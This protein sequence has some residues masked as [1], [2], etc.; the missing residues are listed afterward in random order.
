MAPR[1]P[2]TDT[3]IDRRVKFLIEEA[4]SP[5]GIRDQVVTIAFRVITNWIAVGDDVSS[6]NLKR[7]CL[8]RSRA[9]HELCLASD[10]KT[11]CANTIN[12]HQNPIKRS[13]AWM[14]EEGRTAA[15]VMAH[16]AQWPVVVVTKVENASLRDEVGVSPRERYLRAG[17]EILTKHDDGTWRTPESV[18]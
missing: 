11:W 13:W 6:D 14:R 2:V 4:R 12:E 1:I 7:R 15:E 17:I 10:F 3:Q 9:A 5:D 8:F 16:L 18:V